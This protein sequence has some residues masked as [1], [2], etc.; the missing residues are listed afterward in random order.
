MEVI[1][2]K[3]DNKKVTQ[4]EDQKA[5]SRILS[6]HQNYSESSF[7]SLSY[8]ANQEVK[9]YFE[10]IEILNFKNKTY[11]FEQLDTLA[12]NTYGKPY[13]DCSLE[14]QTSQMDDLTSQLSNI[15]VIQADYRATIETIKTLPE[16]DSSKINMKPD[17]SW[18][19]K[20]KEVKKKDNR[21]TPSIV[22][23]QG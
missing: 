7:D 6:K 13:K 12:L 23:R 18:I 3:L 9:S 17:L 15:E 14:E 19:Y 16:V 20:V 22:S 11:I 21:K 2:S 1:M 4:S 8:K 10:A 5:W